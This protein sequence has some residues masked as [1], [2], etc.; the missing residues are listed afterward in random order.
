MTPTPFTLKP[1]FMQNESVL[2]TLSFEFL[3]NHTDTGHSFM[4]YFYR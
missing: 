1:I 4:W 3:L 2:Q